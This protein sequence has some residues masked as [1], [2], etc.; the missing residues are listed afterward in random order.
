MVY[1][2]L[3]VLVAQ[4]A[5]QD[6]NETFALEG[7]GEDGAD[8][9]ELDASPSTTSVSAARGSLL[10]GRNAS[11]E[12]SIEHGAPLSAIVDAIIP[13]IGHPA[14]NG[15]WCV[16]DPVPRASPSPKDHRLCKD[17]RNPSFESVDRALMETKELLETGDVV[18]CH[19][20]L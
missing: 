12:A 16:G 15:T 19:S 18:R 14:A 1:N 5:T 3:H 13:S 6:L 9:G 8:A 17:G 20:D 11:Y 4:D 10:D 7:H 2:G